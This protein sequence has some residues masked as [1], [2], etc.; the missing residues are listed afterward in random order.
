M[1]LLRLLFSGIL[2]LDK[3]NNNNLYNRFICDILPVVS[4]KY[5][6]KKYRLV[7]YFLQIDFRLLNPIFLIFKFKKNIVL[8]P[9]GGPNPKG[10]LFLQGSHDLH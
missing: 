8:V 1:V 6:Q 9:A 2:V 7:G 10:V 5:C 4:S 3:E